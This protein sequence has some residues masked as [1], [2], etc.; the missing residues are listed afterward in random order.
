MNLR[1]FQWSDSI[2]FLFAMLFIRLIWWE[3]YEWRASSCFSIPYNFLVEIIIFGID[4]FKNQFA[5]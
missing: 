5:Y 4:Q 1:Y 3:N 2:W